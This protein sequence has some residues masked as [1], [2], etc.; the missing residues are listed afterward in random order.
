MSLG[1]LPDMA[2]IKKMFPAILDMKNAKVQ[3][4]FFQNSTKDRTTHFNISVTVKRGRNKN[5]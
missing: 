3:K 1:L 5:K 4:V 2:L